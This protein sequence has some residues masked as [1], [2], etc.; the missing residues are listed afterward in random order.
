MMGKRCLRPTAYGHE[1]HPLFE[2]LSGAKRQGG[3]LLLAW[4]G[5]PLGKGEEQTPTETVPR[6][7]CQGSQEHEL[8]DGFL[9]D[10][11]S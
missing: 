5:Y 1:D 7:K 8:P 10:A 2:L 11:L 9:D 6:P 3:K 4:H